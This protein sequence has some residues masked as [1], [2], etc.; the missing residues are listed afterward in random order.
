MQNQ[1]EQ[2]GLDRA[3]E[4][5][6][7]KAYREAYDLSGQYLRTVPEDAEAHFIRSVSVGKLSGKDFRYRQEMFS[8]LRAAMNASAPE[9]LREEYLIRL[10][11]LLEERFEPYLR[12]RPGFVFSS[13]P[14]AAEYLN[15]CA[16]GLE[17]ADALLEAIPENLTLPRSETVR[18]LGTLCHA[19]KAPYFYEDVSVS[20]NVPVTKKIR[21]RYGIRRSLRANAIYKKA[22]RVFQSLPMG[23]GEEEALALEASRAEA[24]YQAGE[25]RLKAAQE[26]TDKLEL[27]RAQAERQ[28]LLQAKTDTAKALES[29]RAAH[30]KKRL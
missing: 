14:E 5:L 24:R 15:A 21:V 26:G 7:R 6:F 10:A 3:R 2:T 20:S 29:Y 12:V 13:K 17:A 23:S 1:D 27:I 19:V 4:A 30:R 25:A 28:A 11:K 9:A 22:D 8:E 18:L 16:D